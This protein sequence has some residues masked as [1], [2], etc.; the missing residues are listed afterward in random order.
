MGDICALFAVVWQSV[1]SGFWQ[2]RNPGVDA[3][4]GHRDRQ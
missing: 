3:R 2:Q 4:I 1:Y